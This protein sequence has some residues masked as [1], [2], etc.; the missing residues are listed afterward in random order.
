VEPADCYRHLR[1]LLS[2][3]LRNFRSGGIPRVLKGRNLQHLPRILVLEDDAFIAMSIAETLADAGYD[4]TIAASLDEAEAI[5]A[6]QHINA[7]TLDF[8]IGGR[9][10]RTLVDLLQER[11]IPF[12]FCTGSMEIELR[13][14]F[15]TDVIVLGKPFRDTD[16]VAAVTS[17]LQLTTAPPPSHPQ[18]SSAA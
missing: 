1:S 3:N 15:A 8:R 11:G 7:A 12:I 16:L 10:C 14:H 9:D 18:P 6:N 4:T 5:L 2:E 17:I 13:E